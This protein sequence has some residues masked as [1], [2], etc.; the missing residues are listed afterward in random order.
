MQVASEYFGSI[1]VCHS[2]I[3][4]KRVVSMSNEVIL[5]IYTSKGRV[6][7]KGA[8]SSDVKEGLLFG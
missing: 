4:K 2:E 3:E 8:H 5:A 1:S 6:A 7:T